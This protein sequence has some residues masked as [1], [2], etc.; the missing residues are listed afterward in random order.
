MTEINTTARLQA[1]FKQA[2]RLIL[3][4]IEGELWASDGF[5]LIPV[6]EHSLVAE[7]LAEFNLPFEPM[8]CDVRR[9]VV[10]RKADVIPN[11]AS[12]L[13]D[14]SALKPLKPELIDGHEVYINGGDAMVWTTG[15][16]LILLDATRVAITERFTPGA[17]WMASGGLRRL[18]A[19]V[20]NDRAVG[21]LM[22]VRAGSP[23]LRK[24]AAA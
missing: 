4:E 1:Y 12:L 7:L 19:R 18:V 8:V 6:D 3:S 16:H 22:P 15:A 17:Q 23:R 21:L 20:L 13:P 10:Q 14:T 5:L 24:S 11:L 9:T 2:G